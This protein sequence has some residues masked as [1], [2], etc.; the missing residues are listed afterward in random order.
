MLKKV[1]DRYKSLSENNKI[2]LKNV[3]GAFGVK[4]QK[5]EIRAS[6]SWTPHQKRHPLHSLLQRCAETS[7]KTDS[8]AFIQYI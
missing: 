1:F 5:Y 8:Y 6:V 4:L 3:I 7:S 2:V